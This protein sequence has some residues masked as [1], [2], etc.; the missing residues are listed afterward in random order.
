MIE[1]MMKNESYLN[2]L[3]FHGNV[4]VKLWVSI[5]GPYV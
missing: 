2:L 1:K 4:Y 3:K 5:P